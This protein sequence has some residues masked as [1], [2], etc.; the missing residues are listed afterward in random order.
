[1]LSFATTSEP[2][3][4]H[5]L[6]WERTTIV[7]AGTSG[8]RGVTRHDL[9]KMARAATAIAKHKGHKQTPTLHLFR[10]SLLILSAFC[11]PDWVDRTIIKGRNTFL[12]LRSNEGRHDLILMRLM[13]L[14]E[15]L[16]NLQYELGLGSGWKLSSAL[17]LSHTLQ[18]LRLPKS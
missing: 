9:R 2:E 15:M 13:E 11:G 7:A 18:N 1:M 12:G 6:A 17:M 16:F 3:P 8:S 14:A 4:M 10:T 5:Q